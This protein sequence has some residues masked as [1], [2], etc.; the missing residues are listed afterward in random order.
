MD[1]LVRNM[2]PEL[3]RQLK[4]RAAA[5]GEKI[6]EAIA[7]AAEYILSGRGV[8]TEMDAN[9]SAYAAS[10]RRL[11]KEHPGE[12]VVFCGG[13]FRGAAGSLEGAADIVRTS[14]RP[15]GLVAKMGEDLPR[16]GD[17][18]WSSLELFAA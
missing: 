9:N 15:K 8:A 17:W 7:E 16:G 5:K 1:V 4:A 3:Y 14:G 13:A 6:S 12:Y 2:D 18:L 10:K 11:A